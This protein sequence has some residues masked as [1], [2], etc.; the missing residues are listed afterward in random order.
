MV[1]PKRYVLP[2]LEERGVISPDCDAT[3]LDRDVPP[4]PR[5]DFRV[6]VQLGAPIGTK[7][8]V[9]DAP[10]R[11]VELAAADRTLQ[12]EVQ[13]RTLGWRRF[14]SEHGVGRDAVLHGLRDLRP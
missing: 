3:C 4:I 7:V 6:D 12:V 2:E 8:Q 14:A 5:D 11:T 13:A 10:D 1:A 9:V